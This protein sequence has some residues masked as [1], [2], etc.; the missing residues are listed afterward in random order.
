MEKF[1]LRLF[2]VILIIFGGLCGYS[3]SA[4]TERFFA[5]GLPPGLLWSNSVAMILLGVVVG[6]VLAPVCTSLVVKSVV[7]L[8]STLKKLPVQ[9]VL[10]GS[11]GL[12]FGLIVAFFVNLSLEKVSFN[13]IPVIGDYLGPMFIV[14]STIFLGTLGTWFGSQLAYVHSLGKLVSASGLPVSRIVLLDTSVIIDGRIVMLRES[15]FLDGSIVVP[16]FVLQELQTLA[17]SEDML[18]RNRG[19]RGLDLLNDLRKADDIEIINR[20]FPEHGVDAK[21]IQLALELSAHLCT[22]DFNLAKV[23]AVQGVKVL[24]VNVLTS[25]L[26]PVVIA[27]ET[28]TIKVIKA[29]KEAGQGVGY[30]DD[31]TMIVVEGGRR[32]VGESVDV[33][34]ASVVQ[35]AAGRMFFSRCLGKKGSN[36]HQNSLT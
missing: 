28:M 30:L 32:Y 24:N 21:L 33:E 26:K 1:L 16:R 23:A 4:H 13:A 31:G 2:Y 8:A 34:V 36:V 3:L 25:A 22:T 18:K 7:A 19:R 27:G 20:D 17:D 11:I 12:L 35:T 5:Q 29:G 9:E 15:G 6:Y 10:M 14:I